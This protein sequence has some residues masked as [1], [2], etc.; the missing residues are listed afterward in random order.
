M[1][2]TIVLFDDHS[3][4]R[5]GLTLLLESEPNYQVLRLDGKTR[6]VAA[7][8]KHLHQGVLVM[9]MIAPNPSILKSVMKIQDRAP[10]TRILYFAIV[11]NFA[12]VVETGITESIAY[13]LEASTTKKL[14]H[15]MREVIAGRQQ[16]SS[17]Y[18]NQVRKIKHGLKANPGQTDPIETLTPRERDVLRLVGH[19]LSSAEIANRLVISPRTVDMHRWHIMRKLKLR[20]QA[21]LARYAIRHG[22]DTQ[23]G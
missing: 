8:L 17:T 11:G 19:G 7:K 13:T 4:Q 2:T 14:V 23:E 12:C 21:A 10:E 20:G 9:E 18:R 3:E 16:L 6:S 15:A 1:S 5:E 22:L